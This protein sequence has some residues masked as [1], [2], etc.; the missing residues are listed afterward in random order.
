MADDFDLAIEKRPEAI[1][2][3]PWFEGVSAIDRKLRALLDSEGV[4]ADRRAGRA[5]PSTRA[6]TRRSSTCP[7]AACPRARSSSR[8]GAGTGCAIG[9]CDPALVAVAGAPADAAADDRPN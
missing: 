5:R 9:S 1:A 3:D 7:A 2:A 6:S 8:S 4:T